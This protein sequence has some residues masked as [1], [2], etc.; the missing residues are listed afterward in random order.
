MIRYLVLAGLAL[1]VTACGTNGGPSGTSQPTGEAPGSTPSTSV[2]SPSEPPS[3]S[4]NVVVGLATT[5]ELFFGDFGPK[6]PAKQ[7]VKLVNKTS[8]ASSDLAK[9]EDVA[10]TIEGISARAKPALRPYLD[11]KRTSAGFRTGH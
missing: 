11:A 9:Y 7:V 2:A 3:D 6:T 1:L 10:D 4:S 8:L 5:C